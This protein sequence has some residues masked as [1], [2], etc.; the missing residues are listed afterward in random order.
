MSGEYEKVTLL[1]LVA[2]RTKESSSPSLTVLFP[3]SVKLSV[4]ANAADDSMNR[5]MIVIITRTLFFFI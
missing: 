1:L 4:S 3:G 5:D 2:V